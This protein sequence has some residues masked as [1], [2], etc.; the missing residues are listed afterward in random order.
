MGRPL[1]LA[2]LLAGS[3]LVAVLAAPVQAHGSYE[4][5]E[6]EVHL[7]NDEGS[8]AIEAYGGYDIQDLFIGFA[9]DPDVGAG[10][11]GDGFYLRIIL[12]GLHENAATAGA[13]QAVPLPWTVTVEATTPAGVL[14][15][16][17]SSTDGVTVTGD[18]D[19]LEYEVDTAERTTLVQ[20]AFVSYA[21][22]GLAPGQA[23][24]PFRVL[25]RVGDDLRDV[26]PGG[27]PVP[28]SDGAA[29]YPE[30]T[31][32]EGRGVVTE[33]VAL[34][35]PTA[36][37]DIDAVASA[38][39]TYRLNVSSALTQGAQHAML[40]P[41]SSASWDVRTE[42]ETMSEVSANVTLSF[43][44]HA[45]PKADVADPGPLELT[46]TTDVGGRSV[47]TVSPDG[48]VLLPDGTAVPPAPAAAAKESPGLPFAL[49][50]VALA[51]LAGRRRL[52]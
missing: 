18:F 23:I 39:G 44:L 20:R 2:W 16:S 32:I 21:G 11:A 28:G 51:L 12:Y 8:D 42:G 35:A 10:L 27:I 4:A 9:H 49:V 25:S 34:Q 33:T 45:T 17:L 29:E 3:A 36:Y 38:P 41:V 22:S 30:P 14:T 1:S 50:L 37:V 7:L 24:G 6:L 15:R 13:G 48:T 26:A 52:A 47:V 43:V 5:N 19:S 46:V 40:Q 31:A